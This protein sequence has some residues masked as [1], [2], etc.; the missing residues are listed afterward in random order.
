[1]VL[2]D[3]YFRTFF[4][5]G[6]QYGTAFVIRIDGHEYLVTARHLIDTSTPTFNFKVFAND[7]WS[8][9]E[10]VAVGHGNGEV[11]I[12]LYECPPSLRS[13]EFTLLPEIGRAHV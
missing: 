9:V 5:K 7:T 11:D 6:L 2:T 10:A 13:T 12:S 8:E 3:A 1:M 4:I